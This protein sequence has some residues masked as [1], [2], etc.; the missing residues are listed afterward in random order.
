MLKRNIA[1]L[2]ITGGLFAAHANLAAA[3][4]T[5]SAEKAGATAA[6]LK[7]AQ[8]DRVAASG[9]YAGATRTC[10]C[11]EPASRDNMGSGGSSSP[12]PWDNSK[13]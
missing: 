10:N 1:A 9:A 3:H 11:D 7:V 8:T 12:F 4:E 2:M 13:D 6:V 5:A